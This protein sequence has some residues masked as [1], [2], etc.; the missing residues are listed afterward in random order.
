M[1]LLA[2]DIAT[3]FG[4][5]YGPGQIESGADSMP[6]VPDGRLLCIFQDALIA[7]ILRRRPYKIVIEQPFF[8]PMKFQ[9][10]QWRRWLML[11]GVAHATSWRLGLGQAEELSVRTIKRTFTGNTYANKDQIIAE[12]RRRGWNPK[13]DDEADALAVMSCAAGLSRSFHLEAQR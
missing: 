1:D 12:C 8:D 3:R 2:L 11:L 4:W 9:P 5:A 10:M 13:S 7:L 6:D